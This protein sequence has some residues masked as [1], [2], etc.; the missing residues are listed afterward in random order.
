MLSGFLWIIL[1]TIIEFLNFEI[2]TKYFGIFCV[3]VGHSITASLIAKYIY[4]D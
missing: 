3:V 2:N 1:G 4:N